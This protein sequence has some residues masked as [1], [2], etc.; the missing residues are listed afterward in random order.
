MDKKRLIAMLEGLECLNIEELTKQSP[1]H[2]RGIA[3]EITKYAK[4]GAAI[5]QVFPWCK[6]V[7]LK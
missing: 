2:L 7:V 1:E 5:D 6:N 3:A 4:I